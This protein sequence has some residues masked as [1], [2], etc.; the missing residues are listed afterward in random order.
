M[1]LP[2]E[3]RWP[4]LLYNIL[5]PFA[6]A[7]MLPGMLRR[8][9]RRGN[10]AHDFGQRFGFYSRTARERFTGHSWTWIRAVSVGECLIALRLIREL[11][12]QD[13][14]LNIILS[15][16]TS[17]GFEVASKSKSEKLH[18]VYSPI[19]LTFAVRRALKLV[20]PERL[21]FIE[22]EIWPHFTAEAYL[23]GIPMVLAN[24]RMS[25]RSERR[26]V[27]FRRVAGPFFRLLSL[28]CVQEQSDEKR[29]QRAGAR[30]EQLRSPGSIKYDGT[31]VPSERLAEFRHLLKRIGVPPDTPILLGGS[32]FP[33]EEEMLTRV[34]LALR[35]RFP[36][37]LLILVPRHFER[38]PEI[39][40]VLRRINFSFVR[41]T[42]AENADLPAR[43][44]CLIVDTTG[45]L[46]DWYHTATVTFIGKSMDTFGG[47][48]PVEAVLARKP[49]VFGPH[50]ENFQSLVDQWLEDEAA[51]QVESEAELES[52]LAELLDSPEK[53][54]RLAKRASRALE[55]HVGATARTAEIIRQLRVENHG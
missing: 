33:G 50:M 42:Q 3:T 46:R 6:L 35:Q 37:L 54:D 16:T 48:N 39:E 22:G 8:M 21:V 41:R 43:P 36:T 29:W 51:I 1:H 49:V 38:T 24:A 9:I 12:E 5:F 52:A 17:T 45:E 14:S 32:T 26:F 10:Y 4:L 25:P 2:R 20:N 34:T 11:Q 19:D 18:V 23:R 44:D 30:V 27:R 7:M 28:I 15:T 40:V 13:P 31:G 47:Q 55:P 53:R